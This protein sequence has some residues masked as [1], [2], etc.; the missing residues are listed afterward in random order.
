VGNGTVTKVPDQA[1]YD[2]GSTVQ[3]TAVPGPGWTFVGWSGALSGNTNPANLVMDGDKT[4]TA[5]FADTQAPQVT[6]LYPN[7]GEVLIVGLPALLEWTATDNDAV[8]RVDLYVS[9]DNGAT[10]E[11]IA[12]NVPNT[13]SYLWTPPP[14]GTNVGPIPNFTALFLV[15]A[16][17]DAFNQGSDQSDAPF[18]IFDLATQV[19]VTKLDAETVDDGVAVKWA[20]SARGVFQ[21]M[22]LERADAETGPW[23]SVNADLRQDGELTVAVDHT[24]RGGQS[25][26]Y[27][28]VGTTAG[29]QQ[30]TFGPVQGVGGSPREFALSGAWPNP[31]KGTMNLEF[32][33]ARE[34]NIRLSVL[35][36][37]GRQVQ[38]L[39]EGLYRPGRYAVQWDGRTDRGVAPA[40]LYFV[41]YQT[42]G[43]TFTTRLVITP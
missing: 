18:S 13:G 39:A 1:T 31:T 7:G 24:A 40:G 17:D 15:L 43:R 11:A 25:Y 27:R 42:P 28:L 33:V 22:T 9:R 5:F 38:M 19:V 20:L 3:L 34:A 35:D 23:N 21:A 8:T 10:Y 16:Y 37:Q 30:A 36:V 26:W 29:G 6:V 41:R 32:A 2:C 4:V 12:L 14:P